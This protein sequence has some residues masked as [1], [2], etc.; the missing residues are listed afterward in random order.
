MERGT[1]IVGTPDEAI[2]AIEVVIERSGGIGGIL[3]LGHEW[4]TTEYI[5][6]SYELFARYVM[7]HFQGQLGTMVENRDWI[8]THGADVCGGVMKAFEDAKQ[9]LPEVLQPKR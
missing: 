6:E 7:P 4:T 3:S 9:P 8:E 1:L 5:N 2:K